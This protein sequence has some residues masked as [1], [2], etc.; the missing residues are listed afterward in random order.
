[1]QHNLIQTEEAS[2][3]PW[4]PAQKTGCSRSRDRRPEVQRWETQKPPKKGHTTT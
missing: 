3:G 4:P 1:M 2:R